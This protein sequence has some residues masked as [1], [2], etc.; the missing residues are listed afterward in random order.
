MRLWGDVV[1]KLVSVLIVMYS[2]LQG[3]PIAAILFG[4]VAFSLASI[5]LE[6]DARKPSRNTDLRVIYK[7]SPWV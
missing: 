1:A 7:A 2:A 6:I 4:V 5:D 3:G